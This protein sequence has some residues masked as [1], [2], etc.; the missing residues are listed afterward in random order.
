MSKSYSHQLLVIFSFVAIYLIW[1]TTYLAI[2]LAVKE[3]PPFLVAGLRFSSAGILM[4]AYVILI[5]REKFPSF[6]TIINNLIVGSIILVSGQGLLIWSEQYIASGYASILIATLPL[7]FIIMDK[8]HWKL[9]FNNPFIITGLVLG[10]AGI[11]LL[12]RD[13]LNG[14]IGESDI[15]LQVIASLAVLLGGICWVGGTIYYRSYP[16]PGSMYSNLGWQLILASIVCFAISSI[17]NETEGL[18]WGTISFQ[19]WGSLLYLS[20]A[21]SIIAF[22]AYTWLLNEVPSAIVSTYAYI[23]P[24]IAVF[25]GW[26]IAD[27]I[28]TK[29]QTW[30]MIIILVSAVLVNLNRNR[31]LKKST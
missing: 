21:G 26:L 25:F 5:K 30:G 3:I 15:S 28:I 8:R 31:A 17:F 11:L 2:A 24:I 13:H 29:N 22:I 14:P 18:E 4:L 16:S 19:A 23:N 1:G 7:W 10:F 12:F 9:Y 6:K 27:E 20:I